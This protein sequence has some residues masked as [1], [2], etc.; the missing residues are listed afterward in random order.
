MNDKEKQV[1]DRPRSHNVTAFLWG[2]LE[3]PG[4]DDPA[5][6]YHEA[7]KFTRALHPRQGGPG[8][9]LL[10]SGDAS[11]RAST[12]RAVKRHVHLPAVQLPTT[13]LPDTSVKDAITG[14]RS[15]RAFGASPLTLENLATLLRAAYGVTDRD[16]EGEQRFRTVPSGGAL[17]PLDIYP[18]VRNVEGL[19]AGLYHY[20][21]YRE[22]LEVI[23]EGDLVGE[24]AG[25]LVGPP[26]DPDA[27]ANGAVVF[28][29]AGIFWRT[30]FKY[31]LRGYRF[32]LLEAGHIGQNLLLVAEALGLNAFPIGGFYDR[33]VDSVVGLDGVNES[34]IYCV[35]VGSATDQ[36]PAD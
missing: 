36:A 20:D 12:T 25:G 16:P 35:A 23:R 32:V 34:V 24:L 17:Y 5:E 26:E 2:D 18:V 11:T 21:P 3:G 8:A 31:G 7:S 15:R 9:G 30:R 1:S 13:D 28:A 22:V 19:A 29:I 10:E 14:R 6:V 33:T 27:A 4:E